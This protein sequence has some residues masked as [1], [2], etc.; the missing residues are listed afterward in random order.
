MLFVGSDNSTIWGSESLSEGPG[1]QRLA[2][3]SNK[4]LPPGE[5]AMGKFYV[6]DSDYVDV[7]NRGTLL[8]ISEDVAVTPG[9]VWEY[10]SPEP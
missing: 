8:H 9:D 1:G 2:S 3:N 7:N 6:Y 10:I 5:A 4:A